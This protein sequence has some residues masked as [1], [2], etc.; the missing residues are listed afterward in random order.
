MHS[1]VMISGNTIGA[2]QFGSGVLP[3]ASTV[4]GIRFF[5]SS[6]GQNIAGGTFSLYG[7]KEYS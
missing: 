6:A 3:Q 5:N 4:D 1:S 7:I 2:S